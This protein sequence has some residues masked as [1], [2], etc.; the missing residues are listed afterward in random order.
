M[1]DRGLRGFGKTLKC[2]KDFTRKSVQYDLNP[3]FDSAY[4]RDKYLLNYN[5]GLRAI[6][7]VLYV[8]IMALS[9][10]SSY[11]TDYI[12]NWPAIG[13]CKNTNC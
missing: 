3:S 4:T 13:S 12:A 5:G 8:K 6:V 11:C 7:S 10:G 1:S 9:L 2:F